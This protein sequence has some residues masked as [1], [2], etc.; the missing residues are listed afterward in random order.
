MPNSNESGKSQIEY[1]R[2]NALE[3]AYST[4]VVSLLIDP[5]KEQDGVRSPVKLHTEEADLVWVHVVDLGK[6]EIGGVFLAF[7]GV[8]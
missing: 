3:Q 2:S 7:I 4:L 1:P 6:P 8:L 5:L